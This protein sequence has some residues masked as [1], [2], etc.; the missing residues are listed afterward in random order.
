MA[1]VDARKQLD[2]IIK[3]S[4]VHM[5]KP[6][7]IAEILYHHRTDIDVKWSLK[8]LESYRNKSKVWRDEISKK[9]VGRVCTSSARFQDNIFDNNAMN[10][11]NIAELGTENEKNSGAVEAYIYEKIRERIKPLKDIRE[12]LVKAKSSPA[13]FDLDKFIENFEV[14]PGL[15]RSIDKVYEI[16]VYALF[17]TVTKH[18]KAKVSVMVSEGEVL[19]DFEKFTSIVLGVDSKH[20]ILVQDAHLYRAGVTNAADRGLDMWANFGPAIQ[21]KHISVSQEEA[22][23]IS[24]GITADKIVIV[25]KNVEKDVILAV[26]KGLG[27][28]EKVTGVIT[29]EDLSQ[30]Y[31]LCFSSKYLKTMGNEILDALLAEF[32]FEF[33]SATEELVKFMASRKYIAPRSI[34]RK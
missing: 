34:A 15:K 23:D 24:E 28:G 18:L 33:P 7:Q 26:S 31:G 1:L 12:N 17:N 9:I 22:E 19:K 4:R 25:C 3:K 30:W 16:I 29:Q 10:P 13:S 5:Y 11:E 2:S 32:D 21:I 20:P 8:D 14:K 27:V 6:I